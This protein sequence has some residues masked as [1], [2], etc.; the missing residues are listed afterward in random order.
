[1][2]PPAWFRARRYGLSVQLGIATVPAFAP[3]G[4]EA[5]TY[6]QLW[7]RMP[8]VQAW[9]RER[10]ADIATFDDFLPAL[11]LEHL[12]A[13]SLAR[14]AVDA[15]AGYLL[16]VSRSADDLCWWDSAVTDR[17]SARLGPK[18]DVVTELHDAAGH[19]GL[20]LG[21]IHSPG[22]TAAGAAHIAELVDR[23]RPAMLLADPFQ[24]A[25]PL[26]DRLRPA[27]PLADRLRPA[28]P[29]A[30]RLRP[31]MPLADRL[32]P[33]M[34]LADG[35]GPGSRLAAVDG[36]AADLVVAYR[37]AMARLDLP[38]MVDD[39]WPVGDPD[40]TTYD[41][42]PAVTPSGPW[43]L[44]RSLSHSFGYNRAERTA[45]HLTA[46]DIIDLLTE[47]I[48]RGGNL[49]LNLAPR[50]DGTLPDEQTGP[51]CEAGRWVRANADVMGGSPF[52]VWGDDELR[53]TRS[54]GGDVHVVDL[55]SL[56]RRSIAH[57]SP[58]RYPV[59][60]VPGAAHW[61]QDEHGL[62]LEAAPDA[63]R[64]GLATVYRLRLRAR[65]RITLAVR[66][67][68]G[69]GPVT[70]GPTR[71]E[72]VG[73]A[74]AAAATG[75]VVRLGPG[76]HGIETEQFPLVVPAGVTLAGA[77]ASTILD[78]GRRPVGTPTVALDGAGAAL[79][80][81]S[82]VGSPTPD[83]TL[84][85]A[86]QDRLPASF[87]NGPQL[88]DVTAKTLLID[89]RPARSLESALDNGAAAPRRA[90]VPDR[91]ARP[92]ARPLTAVAASGDRSR[93][94]RCEVEGSIEV[95]GGSDVEVAW[96]VVTCGNIRL[97]G[98]ERASVTG[99]RQRDVRAEIGIHLVGGRAHRV[100]AN[101]VTD[102]RCGIRLERCRDASVSAN[103]VAGRWCAV[104]LEHCDG[105][106]ATGNR[107]TGMRAFTVSGG[108][109]NEL[110]ANVADG[111]DT[112]VL[113]EAGADATVV[114]GNH[115]TGCR[116]AVMAWDHRS[117][118]IDGNIVTGTR[119]HERVDG[120]WR[121]RQPSTAGP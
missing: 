73:E 53:Y 5:G 61:S 89:D 116:V 17:T 47:V 115:F 27:M 83:D 84:L 70:I 77:G 4:Q 43:Q 32:R 106:R 3:V 16:P 12:D 9:H 36:S 1:M 8:E 99:N 105:A 40:L 66:G 37:S 6:Q 79:E 30:D 21:L 59:E 48:A 10:H 42:L 91:S 78:G 34:P 68:L 96:S 29:L 92:S 49:V 88:A 65:T 33:A 51:L 74:L 113:L 69:P 52:D 75:D 7:S 2:T 31:A 50:A 20:V 98:T 104:H 76:R 101:T 25:M 19:H 107:V 114:T 55:R 112:G 57:F 58:H 108:A 86:H 87:R 23:F 121:H 95:D 11:T 109:A 39:R 110:T 118:V 100:E 72:T 81:V 117:S 97:V 14:L 120:P 80:Q 85:G 26:A 24:P 13:G 60:A 111:T 90:T 82:V 46:A 38:S 56:S 119:E 54:P 62:H 35:S 93:I 18:R 64:D 103:Q 102:S 44:R 71:F 63:G 41:H 94:E 67:E 45:D 22:G 28:M 15:G